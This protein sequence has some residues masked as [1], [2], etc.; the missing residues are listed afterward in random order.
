MP[1]GSIDFEA[2]LSNLKLK[3]WPQNVGYGA[4]RRERINLGLNKRPGESDS[5]SLKKRKII[6]INISVTFRNV[7]R[8]G[9]KKFERWARLFREMAGTVLFN[10]H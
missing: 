10:L 3:L 7:Y 9:S 4:H 6:P 2:K 1:R 8:I 5:K